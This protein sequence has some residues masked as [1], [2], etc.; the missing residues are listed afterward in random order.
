MHTSQ[1]RPVAEAQNHLIDM[2]PRA[3][4]L[5]LQ[6]RCEP[7][8]LVLSE[9]LCDRGATIRHVYFPVHGFISLLTQVDHHASLEV[10]MVGSEGMFG[11]ELALGML[12]SPLRALVQGPGA[13]WRVGSVAFRRELVRSRALREGVQRYLR[14]VLAQMASSAACLRFHLIQPRLARWL[15]MSADR[16]HAPQFHVTHEFLASM[17]GVRRVSITM[18]ASSLQRDGLIR[19][20]RGEITVLDRQGLEAAACSC[21]ASER[22]AYTTALG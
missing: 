13:A 9:V 12:Q 22:L 1:E 11:A 15:L 19:Y 5:R 3:D 18:A 8:D 14:V 20:H 21:Y 6:A 4:R 17:L 7:V 10:G 2:L 16:A